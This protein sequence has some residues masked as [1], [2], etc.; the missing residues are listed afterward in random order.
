VR[1][2]EDPVLDA[3]LQAIAGQLKPGEQPFHYD[4]REPTL[5]PGR[6]RGE[7]DNRAAYVPPTTVPP[8]VDP[9]LEDAR[10]VTRETLAER[11]ARERITVERGLSAPLPSLEPSLSAR[12]L[13]I[14]RPP[15]D[16]AIG[17][18]RP[19]PPGEVAPPPA[20]PAGEVDKAAAGADAAASPPV[21]RAPD[22]GGARGASASE[23]TAASRPTSSRPAPGAPPRGRGVWIGVAIAGAIAL[24]GGVFLLLGRPA[25]APGPPPLEVPLA[26]DAGVVPDIL[27]PEANGVAEPRP[28]VEPSASAAERP[29][30][31]APSRPVP[32]PKGTGAAGASP[33]R[34]GPEPPAAPPAPM[35]A[36]SGDLPFGKPRF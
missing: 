25:D 1:R 18:P 11:Q 12:G 31:S 36:P 35:G 8:G 15:M 29:V 34:P 20:P 16:V 30:G 9:T 32:A 28:L 27:G 26:I 17:R 13:Q 22:D 6:V 2:G 4:V 19:R 21:L 24:V 5:P 14:P 10:V 3:A 23:R 33:P 7:G